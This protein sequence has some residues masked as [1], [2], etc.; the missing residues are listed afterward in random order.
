MKS[1]AQSLWTIQGI[2]NELHPSV[3]FKSRNKLIA[4]IWYNNTQPN[5]PIFFK[6]FLE[7]INKLNEKGLTMRVGSKLVKL[8]IFVLLG[9]FDLPAK[10]KVLNQTQY[11]GYF[12]CTYCYQKGTYIQQ[13]AIRYPYKDKLDNLRTNDEIR[14]F[15]LGAYKNNIQSISAKEISQLKKTETIQLYKGYKG[16]SP[17]WALPNFEMPFSVVIDYMHQISG[18]LKFIVG[19]YLILLEADLPKFEMKMS[20]IKTISEFSRY[21][22][23]LKEVGQYKS[24]EWI[25]LLLYYGPVLFKDFLNEAYYKN[26]CILSESIFLLLKSEIA[27]EE[28]N[29][30]DV[31]LKEFVRSFELCFGKI[32]MVSNIHLLRHLAECVRQCGPLWCYSAFSFEDENGRLLRYVH[33]ATNV[34]KQIARLLKFRSLF[35]NSNILFTEFI[36]SDVKIFVTDLKR[37]NTIGI[38][39]SYG[40]GKEFQLTGKC[41]LIKHEE[42]HSIGSAQNH[43][44]INLKNRVT[45]NVY[46]KM[47]FNN[48]V[49]NSGPTISTKRTDNSFVKIGHSVCQIIQI[50]H[51]DSDILIIVRKFTP[52]TNIANSLPTHFEIIVLRLFTVHI[53]NVSD[54]IEKCIA[55]YTD[56]EK[57]V[58]V[59]KSYNTFDCD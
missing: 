47:D 11:N 59:T 28:I 27:P 58:Y 39:I 25:N 54:I 23:P 10:A 3:R 31:M 6:C 37:R 49:L 46:Y 51:I 1:K 7:E 38:K 41:S 12:S 20:N 17:L 33:A 45:H 22:R 55:V 53:F 30:A 14:K 44:D 26:F 18:I 13:N 40:S 5:M 50:L 57:Y 35:Y 43:T 19:Q 4:A 9:C 56:E 21:P 8:K 24:S 34:P 36:S 15:M 29:K 48:L 42:L 2:V 52:E 32:H 16:L